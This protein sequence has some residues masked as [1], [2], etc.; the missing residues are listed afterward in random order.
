[1]AG[2][3]GPFSRIQKPIPP[4][5]GSFPLD[6]DGMCKMEMLNY[7]MCLNKKENLSH[8]CRDLSR[9]YLQCRMDNGL[10]ERDDWRNLGFHNDPQDKGKE[11]S[12]NRK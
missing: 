11:D 5:Q 1:M 2:Q 6:H 3:A 7:V 10:M 9:V 12:S 8:E 4:L